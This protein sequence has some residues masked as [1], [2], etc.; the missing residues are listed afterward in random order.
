[1]EEYYEVEG[2]VFRLVS[3]KPM[4]VYIDKTGE[5]KPYTGDISRVFHNS[6]VMTLDEVK[7]YM[8]DLTSKSE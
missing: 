6:H 4:D 1:M 2:A 5:W 7:P 8:S 3:G